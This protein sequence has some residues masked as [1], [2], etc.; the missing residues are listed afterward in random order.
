MA[1]LEPFEV[2]T[3]S[4]ITV[5]AFRDSCTQIDE[6]VVEIVNRRL[7]EVSAAL[8]TPKLILDMT[9][10]D[11][12]GSSF[13]EVMFRTWKKMQEKPGAQFAL[14]GLK[15]Y[16]REVLEITHL[17]RLWAICATR[18]EALAQLK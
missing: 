2:S 5:V 10:V 12:F 7:G 14:C 11:F 15:P 17:D 13:I 9:H 6:S 1:D 3:V 16:C 8:S 18:D 4:G